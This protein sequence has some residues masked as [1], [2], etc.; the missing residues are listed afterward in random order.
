[1]EGLRE[2]SSQNFK[3]NAY[4]IPGVG[5]SVNHWQLRNLLKYDASS[6]V[7]YYTT[8]DSINKLDMSSF[9]SSSYVNLHYNP[10]CYSHAPNG[11]VVTGGLLVNSSKLYLMNIDILLLPESPQPTQ[12][13]QKLSKG[14]FSFYNPD[15]DVAKTVRLGEKINNDVAVFQSSNSNYTAYVCNNDSN[16]YCM[17]ISNNDDFRV[18]NS[19]NCEVNTCLNNVVR[20]PTNDK[21]LAVTGD[22]QSIFLLDPTAS[23]PNV[24]T[25]AS[26]HEAGFGIAYHPSGNLLSAAFQDG[27]CLVYDLRNISENKPLIE[28]K[29][30]RCGHSSGAFRACKF[31]P[32]YDMS[33][34]L[35][36]SEH[37][38][39]VHLVDLRHLDYSNVDDHQVVVVP[40]ALGQYVSIYCDSDSR[41]AQFSSFTSPLIFDYDYLTNNEKL[42][43]DFVFTPPKQSSTSL[44]TDSQFPAKSNSIREN[45]LNSSSPC[46]NTHPTNDNNSHQGNSYRPSLNFINGEMMLS[47]IDFCTPRK[48]NESC[49]LIGCEDAGAVMWGVND[50]TREASA[51]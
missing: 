6:N 45:S 46:M 51:S 30:T 33:D 25:I 37:V 29:S 31:S 38:G 50:A 42:F 34:M 9:V 21:L 19:I 48:A 32:A 8:N 35:I 28:V 1:M 11:V 16:L 23:N 39:R 4:Y 12:N 13:R 17:D 24:R 14:L 47:G 27:T 36:I 41:S 44:K 7:V 26:G 18:V 2:N 20:S 15:L 10:R 43:Q 3:P 22:S 49:I 40:L 5:I